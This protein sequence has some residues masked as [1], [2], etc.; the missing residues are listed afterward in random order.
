MSQSGTDRFRRA[1]TYVE[2]PLL[3]DPLPWQQESCE[4]ASR[5]NAGGPRVSPGMRGRVLHWNGEISKAVPVGRVGKRAV[6]DDDQHGGESRLKA[7]E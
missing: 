1:K 5:R 6:A 4:Q 7:K 3:A 2:R